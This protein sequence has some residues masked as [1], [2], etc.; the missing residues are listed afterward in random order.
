MTNLNKKVT[1]QV[2]IKNII[3]KVG[4]YLVLVFV[5]LCI[6][7]PLYVVLITSF[8]T[9]TEAM[10]P[11]FTFWPKEFD[12]HGYIEVLTYTSGGG[13]E[14]PTVIRGFLNTM[15]ICIPTSIIGVL[16][17][18]LA[19]FAFSKIK[20]KSKNVLF[21][22]LLGTMMIPGTISMIPS[23][24]IFDNIGWT[25]SFLPLIIPGLLG[26]ASCVFFMRQF[27]YS[28][29]DELIECAQIDGL[30]NI[31]I[32]FRVIIPL[33]MPALIAQFLLSF[34]GNY[35]AYLSPLLYLQSPENYTLQIA[36]KFFE[37][38]Y[39]KDYAVVMAGAAISLLPTLILFLFGQKYFIDGIATT[40]IKM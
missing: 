11:S 13:D 9:K 27:F 25:D 39:N 14:L 34:V 17:S 22:I 4:I 28:I 20:F 24:I 32:F 15:I 26:S 1:R 36:L 7:A 37:G 40:G 29:P 18:A 16:V 35:N 33:S 8:K 2:N 21:A 10:D 19:A 5:A 38:T 23:Y 31:G 3:S 30:T 6:L 12:L